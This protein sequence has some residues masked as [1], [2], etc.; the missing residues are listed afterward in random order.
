MWEAFNDIA[1][2]F[3]LTIEEFQE[4]VKAALLSHLKITER[5]L[6][7]DTDKVFRLF[8]DDENNLVDSLEFLSAFALVS[9][10]TPDEKIRYIF[11]LYDFDESQVLS[12]D[13]MVLA[14]RSTLSGLSK[15][16]RIDPPTE[17]E[18]EAIVVQGFELIRKAKS[19]SEND[20]DERNS[21][22]GI[23]KEQFLSYCLNTPEIVSW[24]EFFDDLEEYELDLVNMDVPVPERQSNV[25]RTDA[26]EAVMNPTLGGHT[27]LE[28]E[29]K[30]HA[31]DFMPRQAWQSVVPFVTPVRKPDPPREAP[32][33][34]LTLEWAYGY[35]GHTSRQ[36]L[37]Y[38]AKGCLLYPAGAICVVQNL[39]Y[40]TQEHFMCHTD[41]V[42]SL[43]CYHTAEGKTIAASGEAGMRPAVHVWDVDTMEVLA[44]LRGFHRRGVSEV[45]FSPNRELLATLG[46][47]TY[48]SIAVYDW[49][50]QT[51]MWASRTTYVNVYD[52]RFLTD[53]LIGSCGEDHVYFWQKG[54]GLE[55]KRYR[56]LFG[57][58]VKPEAL[59]TV[60]LVGSTVVT[61]SETGMIYAWEGRNL[62]ST[63]RGHSGVVTSMFVVK[64]GDSKE[65]GLVTACSA[66]KIQIWNERLEI[67]TTFN[68]TTLGPIEPP[69]CSVCWDLLTSKLLVG[70]KTCEIYEMDSS[71]GRNVHMGSVVAAHYNPRVCGLAAH[72]MDPN[73]FVS[74]GDDRS[75]RVFDA[76]DHKQL[77]M[78]LMDSMGH[79]CAFS[80]DA[81][82]ILIGI[83]SGI[84]GKE[85]RKEGAFVVLYEEDLTIV[86][87]AR[88]SKGL[89]ADCKYSPAGDLIALA[90]FDGSIYVYNASDYAAR[91]KCRGHVGK[92]SHL[93]FSHDGQFIM[94]N[95]SAGELLFWDVERGEQQTP[96]LVKEM[97]WET[98]TCVFSYQS[99]GVWGPFDDGIDVHAVERS[100]SKELMVSADSF[101]RLRVFNCPCATEDSNFLTYRGHTADVQNA[102][103]NCDDSFLYTSGGTDGCIL[104]WAVSAP[105]TQDYREM[106]KED[107]VS[108]QLMSEIKF[109]GTN[110]DLMPNKEKVL[111]DLPDAICEMEEGDDDGPPLLPWQRT[112]VAPSRVPL[113]D[114]AEP[115]DSLELEFVSGFAADR[116]RQCLTYGPTAELLFFASTVAVQMNQKQ[117]NQ[118]FYQRHH[119]TITSMAVHPTERI[120]ATGHQSETPSIRVWDAGT[121][122]TLAV[123][124]G[125][126]RRAIFHL[127]FSPD[128]K[129]LASVGGDRFHSLAVYDW[130]SQHIMSQAN[131]FAAKSF[132]MEFDPTGKQII[133][134]GD[135]T[136]RF[137]DTGSLN[138]N[139]KEAL[140]GGRAKLQK[141]LCAGFLGSNAVVGTQDGSLY[142][143]VGRQL[144]GMVMA[145]TGCV[146]CISTT[147]DG[148]CSGGEDGF[149]KIWTRVLE[150]RLII[151]MKNFDCVNTNV[152]SL[153]WDGELGRVLVGTLSCEA[154]EIN[155]EDGENL[156]DGPLLEGHSGEELYGLAVN[157]ANDVFATVGDDAI[158]RVWDVYEHK[159]VK[160]A[161][162]EMP[163]R[164][165]AFAPDGRRIAVGF[166][167]PNKLSA[168]QY[169][170]KWVV[171]DT[172]D[173]QVVHEARDSTKWISDMKYSPNGE[174]LAMGS[175]DNK[176]YVYNVLTGYGLNAV[177]SQHNAPIANLDFSE[178]S[179]WIQSNCNG[180]ELSFFEADTGMFI[181]AASRLRDVIWNTQNCTMG[182]GVQ[183]VWPPQ[184]DGTDVLSSDAN[185]FRGADGCV[186]ATGDN[187][188]RIHLMRYP[189]QSS[190]AV[191]KKYRGA[192][193]PIRRCKFAAGDAYLISLASEDKTIF[194][195]AHKRDREEDV[196]WNVLE[197][198]GEIAEHES[199]VMT[200]LGLSGG[201]DEAL[202]DLSDLKQVVT[203][204]PW[205]A[206]MIAPTEV[207][208]PRITRPGFALEKSHVFGFEGQT[209]RQSVRFNM[210]GAV[211]YPASRYVCVYNKKKNQQTFYEGHELGI[212]CVGVSR[213]GKLAASTEKTSRVSI[214][215]WDACT[216]QI[217]CVLPVLHRRGV[218][219]LQFSND[220]KFLTSVGSDGDHSVALWE[221]PSGEW[222][223]GRLLAYNK[224]DVAPT[225]F[226]CPIQSENFV[227]ASGGRFHQKFWSV[228]GR[229]LN[230]HYA[231]YSNK[232]KLGTLLC[233]ASS[234]QDV[235]VS[236]STTG[237]M[238]VWKGR[239]LDRMMKAHEL[240][241]SAIFGSEQG[242]VTASKDGTIKQW[243]AHVEHLRTFSLSDADVPPLDMCIRS[244][245]A[246]MSL[247]GDSISRILVA[248]SGSEIYEVAAKSG[249]TCL[250]HE[251]HFS[252]ELWG[253]GLNPVDADLFA[254]AG[255]DK[256]VRVWSLSHKRIIRKAVLD[257]TARC[258]SW[259]PD[260]R[261]LI[262]GFGGSWDG[263][264][265]RKD[266]AFIVL[267]SKSLKPMFEGRDSRHW[268]QDV[269]FSPDGKHF[270]VGSMDHKI[271]I[272]N[273]Q[274]YR[275]KGTCDRHNSYIKTFDF[276]ADGV[277]IQSDSGDHEHLY[278]EAEDGQYFASGSQLKDM[279]WS[280]WTCSFGWPVQGAWP[281]FDDVAKGTAKEPSTMHRSFDQQLLSVGDMDGNIKLQH[282]P[283]TEKESVPVA[284]KGHVDEVSKVRFTCDNKYVVSMGKLDRSIIVWK[285]VPDKYSEER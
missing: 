79:T 273:R 123:I 33:H 240:A 198:G 47:D 206:A 160:T 283:C 143:F 239:K 122:E 226:A 89:I 144:D 188:G 4:I 281:Y 242:I 95:C 5:T 184:R 270:A 172:E 258:V 87:E 213:D 275:M 153:A 56:G 284:S 138:M 159:C 35:N 229:C 199:D 179:A 232:Q 250:M 3:G 125:F 271:Y 233:G 170:G 219:T 97:Q 209:T 246:S 280:D 253:L 257:C 80:P 260:G 210:E 252:G 164:C 169:D 18:V 174:L 109:E 200:L 53:T 50:T 141:F 157:P 86:H 278:F 245:D 107:S 130:R 34:N 267:D 21:Y 142:R 146:N 118:T 108:D 154:Y 201:V 235:F 126:H 259:S 11:A 190:F 189:V 28:Y 65:Q 272:Y 137:W 251:S 43:K 203:S 8:D 27:R 262:V 74:V 261:Q 254:T 177:I 75:V 49:K 82:A 54:E 119:G 218:I 115:G 22:D 204:R 236:G 121:L 269:K 279:K 191:P 16:S 98:N 139:F 83:G 37:S 129:R 158:L 63:V 40:N 127:A 110:I 244:L 61:G 91:A 23:E 103:F 276:S 15:M 176:I 134:C 224:G 171:L 102:K 223:D 187:Y 186:V 112:I 150:C 117:R 222:A 101:G 84:Y 282:W 94:S 106:K 231:E 99:Q 268:I 152:R 19:G 10:M 180:M 215:I 241:I 214:H 136:I 256:T 135:E 6:N 217:I 196:A 202:P 57:S 44:T 42:L 26:L 185:L 264:R 88:D 113:E 255:D 45:D 168:K 96:K 39:A 173:Y 58:A 212:S 193:T 243:T 132:H 90:S 20:D 155:T 81:Q 17:S 211:I 48:N 114:N 14:F 25:S 263:K 151:E 105:E 41:L 78:S 51:R 274:T 76:R 234:V 225:L 67:G 194:Q 165:C 265:Q 181:P 24:I 59:H 167:C 66:G 145:H 70:F 182:W 111:K 266:G 237:N 163:A 52:M 31:K 197:R 100:H 128:G 116:S 207:N 195:W 12:L 38:T 29:K 73:L 71:D 228:D 62:I 247:E 205:V 46:M 249:T 13:E 69:I 227:M 178:D 60:A 166:G 285:V 1:E 93:D 192:A 161:R 277:Y 7:T 133:Q 148:V 248:T 9:G 77:R 120:I 238:F 149:V 162:L 30:G 147:P 208:E 230:S 131:S 68:A 124:E 140:F 72:P 175:V 104:Q 92:V 2:G 55:Y 36:T 32:H 156:H 221:S 183:G 216:T 64:K 220:N 85:E